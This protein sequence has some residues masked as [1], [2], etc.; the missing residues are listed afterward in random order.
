MFLAVAVVVMVKG[1]EVVTQLE[2][3][4]L[5]MAVFILILEMV[6]AME[7]AQSFIESYYLLLTVLLHTHL[8]GLLLLL[9]LCLRLLL[10]SQ[11]LPW[12]LLR[13]FDNPSVLLEKMEAAATVVE[14]YWPLLV[15][16][17]A[18]RVVAV[19]LQIMTGAEGIIINK[20][21]AVL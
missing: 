19:T 21:V 2:M 9:L 16:Q 17:M 6:T 18:P 15:L 12:L 10:A 7:Q 4:A 13:L 1:R 3:E 8:L 11:R 5:L 14:M 20:E